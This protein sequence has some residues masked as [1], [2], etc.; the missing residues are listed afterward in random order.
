M[1]YR[2][3]HYFYHLMYIVLQKVFIFYFKKKKTMLLMLF[4]II[5][6]FCYSYFIRSGNQISMLHGK[7][8]LMFVIACS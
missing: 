3:R 5:L 7:W 1:L 8:I 2:M 6:H 4:E